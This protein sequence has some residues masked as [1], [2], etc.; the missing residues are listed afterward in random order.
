MLEALITPE[1][2]QQPAS[3]LDRDPH[4]LE[5]WLGSLQLLSTQSSASQVLDQLVQLNR[6]QLEPKL[7]YQL[8]QRYQPIIATL[9]RLIQP[10][11]ALSKQPM[12]R[13][14]QELGFLCALLLEQ[15]NG[16]KHTLRDLAEARF[17]LGRKP[18]AAVLV[19]LFS[20][21]L[22]LIWACQRAYAPVPDGVWLQL[23]TL[24]KYAV[25][26]GDISLQLI[27]TAPPSPMLLLYKECLLLSLANLQAFSSLEQLQIR[28][29]IQTDTESC[30]IRKLGDV[31]PGRTGFLL[32]LDQDLP[33][34]LPH[35]EVDPQT[36]IALWL[37]TG[38]LLRQLTRI[39]ERI[40][41]DQLHHGVQPE[42]P[43][44]LWR[45][46]ARRFDNHI[47]R[48]AP[49][50]PEQGSLAVLYG[51]R[52]AA[53]QLNAG[54][55]LSLADAAPLRH[56]PSGRD[57]AGPAYWEILNAGAGGYAL[58][59][60]IEGDHLPCRVGDA[61]LVCDQREVGWLLAAVRWQTVDLEAESTEIGIEI[62]SL[63]P[64]P[65]LLQL[66]PVVAGAAPLHC[67]ALPPWPQMERPALLIAPRGSFGPMRELHLHSAAGEQVLRASRLLEQTPSYELFEF[68]TI[69]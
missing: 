19:D 10:E 59:L 8:M 31:A 40:E 26:R 51:L 21:Y 16:L 5:E 61:L 33:P 57:A 29:I 36:G 34:V 43:V 30:E 64:W 22:A 9:A 6:T 65:A 37:E 3:R 14:K 32:L 41:N 38:P 4:A 47:R 28:R 23:H 2:T 56:A 46:L 24:F 52:Q 12:G 35:Q 13:T 18:I 39:I 20:T 63:S 17:Y 11:Q 55:P 54:Q 48:A 42:I 1:I 45:K 53:V 69:S 66:S 27:S 62:L 60:S 44:L 67:L 25:T 15:A 49:R 58:R 50:Q 68:F 7:R